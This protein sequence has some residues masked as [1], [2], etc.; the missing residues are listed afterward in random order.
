MLAGLSGLLLIALLAVRLLL[1]D[2]PSRRE[3]AS[4]GLLAVLIAIAASFLLLRRALRG[5]H[6]GFLRAYFAGM[7]LRV[8]LLAGIG[9][10]I[11]GATDWD[12]RAF[13]IA[14]AL[15]YPFA[16]A[17]EGWVLSRETPRRT[18]GKTGARQ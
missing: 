4:A 1:A 10:A 17:L 5:S 9:L 12:L 7:L 3:G 15:S 8:L 6:L 18:P 16:I 14:V 11:R 2:E 13:L